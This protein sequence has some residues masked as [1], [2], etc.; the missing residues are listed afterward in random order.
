[1][2]GSNTQ[3]LQRASEVLFEIIGERPQLAPRLAPLSGLLKDLASDVDVRTALQLEQVNT[4]QALLKQA[5]GHMPPPGWPHLEA[6]I[7]WVPTT[8][9]DHHV[10]ALDRLLDRLNHA[11]IDVHA[12][13]ETAANTPERARLLRDIWAHLDRQA[14]QASRTVPPMW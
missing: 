8:P 3:I 11:L 4:I 10:D 14:T 12:W 9:A 13:C 1:M 7:R 2:S 5:N 6:L